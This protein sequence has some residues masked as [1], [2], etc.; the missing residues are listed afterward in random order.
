MCVC[1]HILLNV[2]ICECIYIALMPAC[3][4]VCM[5]IHWRVGLKWGFC[6]YKIFIYF[7]WSISVEIP[8]NNSSLS[9]SRYCPYARF[10]CWLWYMYFHVVDLQIILYVIY[11]WTKVHIYKIHICIHY[12]QPIE[13]HHSYGFL[14]LNF[15]RSFHSTVNNSSKKMLRHKWPTYFLKW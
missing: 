12:K 3:I 14:L 13:V 6:F 8:I 5:T 7:L 15:G 2:C 10:T 1:A 4:Y 11:D 9:L